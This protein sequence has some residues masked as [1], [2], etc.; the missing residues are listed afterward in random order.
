MKR[1]MRTLA[2]VAVLLALLIALLCWPVYRQFQ[3]ERKDQ[4]LITA[5]KAVNE[6]QVMELL[7]EGANTNAHDS[8][9]SP[10]FGQ[11]LR[12][13]L[14][15]LR[16]PGTQRKPPRGRSALCLSLQMLDPGDIRYDEHYERIALALLDHGANPNDAI[17]LG[18]TDSL[19]ALAFTSGLGKHALVKKILEKGA[20]PN[21]HHGLLLLKWADAESSRLMIAHGA[22][23]NTVD[24]FGETALMGAVVTDDIEMVRF[25]L[26][27]GAKVDVK[28]R[29]GITAMTMP[30]RGSSP[31]RTKILALLR[32]YGAK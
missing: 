30:I 4:E 9:E 25:L 24:Q 27:H 6:G 19:S 2:V 5:I 13:F 26:Q 15:R 1:R 20:D 28:N 32:Q 3:K 16:H 31:N 7:Q 12:Q 22:D 11:V 14:D 21:I 29:Q 17:P 10:S 18:R 8:R 23:V